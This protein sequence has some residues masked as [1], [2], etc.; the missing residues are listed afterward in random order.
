MPQHSKSN[1]TQK[2]DVAEIR[3]KIKKLQTLI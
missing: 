3:H 1:T 2:Y